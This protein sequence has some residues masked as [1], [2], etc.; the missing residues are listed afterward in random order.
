MPV[1]ANGQ[2]AFAVYMRQP[3]GSHTAF[4]LQLPTVTAAGISH[5]ACFF[6][7]NLFA[8]FGLPDTLTTSP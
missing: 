3:D 5:V 1:S 7:T 8:R 4:Q 6:D 2:P